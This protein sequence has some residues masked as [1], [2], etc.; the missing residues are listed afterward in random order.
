MQLAGGRESV[1]LVRVPGFEA[2]D[3]VQSRWEQRHWQ[4][5]STA[6]NQYPLPVWLR[7]PMQAWK[8]GLPERSGA[9]N[10]K[11]ELFALTTSVGIR[12]TGTRKPKCRGGVDKF[13]YR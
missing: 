9:A 1:L 3:A 6:E 7:T 8:G 10:G 12:S 2:G 4:V 11:A 13:P 5:S